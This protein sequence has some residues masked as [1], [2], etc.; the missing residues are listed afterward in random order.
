MKI[1]NLREYYPFYNADTFLEVPDEVALILEEEK[2][3]QI[4]YEQ[5]IR[6]NKAFYSL[7]TGDGIEASAL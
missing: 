1:I 2:R 5:Y 4:N 3:L 6:D 7:D